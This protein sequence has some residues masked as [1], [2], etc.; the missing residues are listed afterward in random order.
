MSRASKCMMTSLLNGNAATFNSARQCQ[1]MTLTRQVHSDM[2]MC[3]ALH[4]VASCS[5]SELASAPDEL[6]SP[7]LL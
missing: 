6:W 4:C 5:C 2:Q 1:S 3:D 7:V